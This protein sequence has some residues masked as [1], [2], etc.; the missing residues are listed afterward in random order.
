MQRRT[1]SK[2]FWGCSFP[3][4]CSARFELLGRP[5]K[6]SYEGFTPWLHLYAMARVS[7][8]INYLTATLPMERST[9][10]NDVP[11]VR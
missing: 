10:V 1:N 9:G 3:C 4:R 5:R 11:A 7:G 2:A 8:E 6:Y